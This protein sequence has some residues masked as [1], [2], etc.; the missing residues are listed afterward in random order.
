MKLRINLFTALALSA[1]STISVASTN[2]KLD[3]GFNHA[4]GGYFAVGTTDPYWQVISKY[5]LLP[6]L[7]VSPANVVPSTGWLPPPGL[8]HWISGFTNGTSPSVTGPYDPGYTVYRK[9]FCVMPEALV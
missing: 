1:A 3:T 8:A 5:P 6:P 4:T 7:P 2:F 9:C